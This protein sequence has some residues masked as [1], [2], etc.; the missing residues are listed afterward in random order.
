VINL[1]KKIVILVIIAFF[2]I[3]SI[4][5][6]YPGDG[7]CRNYHEIIQIDVPIDN[8]A[9]IVLDGVANEDFWSKPKNQIGNVTIP[10]ATIRYNDS[11]PPDRMLNMSAI[12]IKNNQNLY[13]LCQWEDNTTSAEV[14]VTD[15]LLFCWDINVINFT[16]YYP[17]GMSTD[18]MGGGKIDSWKWYHHSSV[19]SGIPFLCEDD[20]F[21]DDGWINP[22]PELSDVSAAFTCVSNVSYTLE[23]SRPLVTGEEYDVQFNNHKEYLFNIAVYDNDLHEN[24][25]MSWTCSLDLTVETPPPSIPGY[26]PL[27]MMTLTTIGIILLLLQKRLKIII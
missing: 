9:N 20:C 6:A 26:L 5:N 16:A 10:L 1:K 2:T 7:D 27:I 21:Q 14:Y 15:G 18:H 22:N 3:S 25:L 23:I 4:G 17:F 19:S 11:K 12:F 8:S 13:I 24:H